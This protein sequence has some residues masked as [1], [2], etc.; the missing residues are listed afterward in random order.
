MKQEPTENQKN[1]KSEI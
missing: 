1:T